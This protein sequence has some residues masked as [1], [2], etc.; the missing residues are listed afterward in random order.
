VSIQ[1]REI[2]MKIWVLKNFGLD[3]KN[4]AKGSEL[5]VDVAHFGDNIDTF[6]NEGYF[7]EITTPTAPA[8]ETP[9]GE[10]IAT[11]V[12]DHSRFQGLNKPLLPE[13]DPAA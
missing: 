10:P 12:V 3:G 7:E 1:G 2:N 4:L 6:R 13:T 11:P 5:D 8:A 9:S